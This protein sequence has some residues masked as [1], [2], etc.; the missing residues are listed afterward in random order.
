MTAAGSRGQASVEAIG[1]WL[2]VAL[3]CA[4]LVVGIV[5]VAPLVAR[6]LDGDRDPERPAAHAVLER[7]VDT[8]RPTLLAARRLLVREVGAA[9]ADRYL[10]TR[11]LARYGSRLGRTRDASA[12]VG[13]APSPTVRLLAVPSGPP[14]VV[15]ATPSDEPLP[16]T[17]RDLGPIASEAGRQALEESLD[18]NRATRPLARILR[19]ADLGLAVIGLLAPGDEVG[20][21]P[22]LRAGDGVLC[23]P[24]ELRWLRAGE[25]D[26]QPLALAVHVVV[27][28]NG[29]V[30]A[31]QLLAG[32]RC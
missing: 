12:V 3:L 28:R 9:A 26:T 30:L 19:G 23:E 21:P 25:L 2:A 13:V 10:S 18:A 7:A 20:P 8:G 14:T 15:I 31:D 4:A 27:V 32:E 17:D 22:G 11:I 24:I 6:A 29:R 5:R 16:E 1:L